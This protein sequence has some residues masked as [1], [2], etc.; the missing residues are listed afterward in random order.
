MSR[1]NANDQVQN[2]HTSQAHRG[3]N[4]NGNGPTCNEKA[5]S[6]KLIRY[7]QNP[8]LDCFRSPAAVF[9]VQGLYR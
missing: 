3:T 1:T 5:S 9:R 7:D 2:Q 4:D 8:F 6:S